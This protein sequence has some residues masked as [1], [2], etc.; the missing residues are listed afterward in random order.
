[1]AF[2][3]N[4]ILACIRHRDI[5]HQFKRLIKSKAMRN[6]EISGIPC[7]T[8]IDLNGIP[9]IGNV[10]EI[11][12]ASETRKLRRNVTAI[13]MEMLNGNPCQK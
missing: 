11:N 6:S 13:L 12:R 8:E 2:K 10:T 7:S 4:L 1:M 3:F 5:I 9:T